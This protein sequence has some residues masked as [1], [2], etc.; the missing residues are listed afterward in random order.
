MSLATG[1]P[2]PATFADVRENAARSWLAVPM[3]RASDLSGFSW[4][5]VLHEPEFDV[6]SAGSKNRQTE[7]C[8]VRTY[9]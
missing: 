2:I 9:F 4:V 5:S 3:M 1:R 6:S 8:V 7:S